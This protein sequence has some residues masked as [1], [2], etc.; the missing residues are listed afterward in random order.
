MRWQPGQ[1]WSGISVS[2]QREYALERVGNRVGEI[3]KNEYYP[4]LWRVV[5][6]ARNRTQ[7]FTHDFGFHSL[8]GAMYLQMMRLLTDA[9][10]VRQ[11]QRPGCWE[12]LPPGSNKNRMYC[13]RARANNGST[14][15]GSP[16]ITYTDLHHY[17]TTEGAIPC[18]GV[19]AGEEKSA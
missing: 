7:G 8:L 3:V 14:I 9:N 12:T 4:R 17:Y 16:D 2:K 11:C 18:N 6:E 15:M 1:N 10:N 13:S 19:Q 5:N